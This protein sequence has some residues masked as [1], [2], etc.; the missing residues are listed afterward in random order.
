MRLFIAGPMRGYEYYNAE[1]FGIAAAQLRDHGYDVVSPVELD[2]A[3]GFDHYRDIAAP[4]LV[5]RFQEAT[6]K[7]LRTC[8]GVALLSGWLKSK[9]VADEIAVAKTMG[10]PYW[11]VADWIRRAQPRRLASK[12]DDGHAAHINGHAASLDEKSY[13]LGAIRHG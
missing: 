2:R 11:P 5:L 9:G 3:K 13:Y 4:I 6:I 10:I 12:A 7:A 1:A 8:E